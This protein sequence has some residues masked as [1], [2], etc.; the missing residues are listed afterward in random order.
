M[1]DLLKAFLEEVNNIQEGD[2]ATREQSREGM[3]TGFKEREEDE[4][5]ISLK[6]KEVTLPDNAQK[7]AEYLRDRDVV[8]NSEEMLTLINAGIHPNVLYD[9]PKWTVDKDNYIRL[10]GIHKTGSHVLVSD[11]KWQYNP[12]REDW[13]FG[14]VL[15]SKTNKP[16]L[17]GMT[18]DEFLEI[19]H[20]PENAKVYADIMKNES[21][22]PDDWLEEM[23]ISM[24]RA[25]NDFDFW[26]EKNKEQYELDKYDRMSVIKAYK[27]INNMG[28]PVEKALKRLGKKI[29][30]EV[31][32][33]DDDTLTFAKEPDQVI[34]ILNDMGIN[35]KRY[36]RFPF[37]VRYD[38][39]DID[40]EDAEYDDSYIIWGVRKKGNDYDTILLK[41]FNKIDPYS[42]ERVLPKKGQRAQEYSVE[43]VKSMIEEFEN[44]EFED[45]N[46]KPNAEDF[47]NSLSHQRSTG[48]KGTHGKMTE[49]T[50]AQI[51]KVLQSMN[52]DEE[53]EGEDL[54]GYY[55][56]GVSTK[57]IKTALQMFEPNMAP[58]VRIF[59]NSSGHAGYKYYLFI[60]D[61]KSEDKYIPIHGTP[62]PWKQF[63]K[64]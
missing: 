13:F 22:D 20:S 41:E 9:K 56:R 44:S 14:P 5:D 33:E 63:T 18:S 46:F 26:Y 38:T 35:G 45:G 21:E 43:D 6:E 54:I 61:E 4:G 11:W 28:L 30:E 17:H 60:P 24:K 58:N 64:R 23:N 2:L 57:R 55:D 51:R 32:T 3:I 15:D 48:R 34:K 50:D 1:S 49:L 29:T 19:I 59:K 37:Y 36:T 47:M 16:Q 27:A 10:E 25:K 53:F 39:E 8:R 42:D 12:Q 62:N 52:T 31:L 7:R 40:P